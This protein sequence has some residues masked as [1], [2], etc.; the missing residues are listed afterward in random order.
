MFI[1]SKHIR[2]ETVKQVEAVRLKADRLR[3]IS[4][5]ILANHQPV[6]VY[7]VP[8]GYFSLLLRTN[9]AG[10]MVQ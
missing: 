9:V 5:V 8:R 1:F 6:V 2:K 4:N 3:A 10:P 7:T